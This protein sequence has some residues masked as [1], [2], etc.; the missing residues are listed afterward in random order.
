MSADFKIAK[1]VFAKHQQNLEAINRLAKPSYK[2]VIE[3]EIS[4]NSPNWTHIT[5]SDVSLSTGP[6]TLREEIDT[7]LDVYGIEEWYTAKC[8]CENDAKY[9][10][11]RVLESCQRAGIFTLPTR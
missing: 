4:L 3:L 10:I 1:T 8:C 7:W 9:W 5:R 11:E 6:E 2:S